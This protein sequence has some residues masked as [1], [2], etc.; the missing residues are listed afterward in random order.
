[1][2]KS[3]SA[4]ECE[5]FRLLR[6]STTWGGYTSYRDWRIDFFKNIFILW[7]GGSNI[8]IVYCPFCAEKLEIKNL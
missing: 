5:E 1:M 7:C 8:E 3:K 4:H 6:D 2:T